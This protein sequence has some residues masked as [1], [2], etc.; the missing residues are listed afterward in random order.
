MARLSSTLPGSISGPRDSQAT[1]VI[2][3]RTCRCNGELGGSVPRV[4]EKQQQFEPL[5]NGGAD[6]ARRENAERK[7]W[8]VRWAGRTSEGWRQGRPRIPQNGSSC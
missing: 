3:D 7:K 4:G 1:S 5:Q 6:D 8:Q 2:Q